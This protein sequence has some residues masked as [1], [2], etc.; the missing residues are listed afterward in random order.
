MLPLIMTTVMP[1]AMMP[2]GA[3][4][5]SSSS[6]LSR[7]MKAL[8]LSDH[9][10]PATSKKTSWNRMK[11]QIAPFL[12]SFLSVSFCMAPP[13][14]AI[15]DQSFPRLVAMSSQTARMMMIQVTTNWT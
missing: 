13:P 4:C 3:D 12:I 2:M 10:R 8:S 9:Q 7:S 1:M 5:L 15:G 11:A 14:Q 6:M